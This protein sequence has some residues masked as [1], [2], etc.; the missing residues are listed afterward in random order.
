MSEKKTLVLP[1]RIVLGRGAMS[2]LGEYAAM[3]GD[4]ALLVASAEDSDRV[5]GILD[6][7]ASRRGVEFLYADF[8]GECCESAVRG[9]EGFCADSGAGVVIGL[10]GGK[11]IDTAKIIAD[12]LDLPMFSV[13]TTAATDA[14][15]SSLAIMYDDARHFVGPVSLR[16]N[17]A[18][19]LIDT[20]IIAK[21]PERFLVSGMGDAFSTFFEA[22]A[23]R[24]ANV[25]NNGGLSTLCAC[26]LAKLGLDTL[27]EK[28]AEALIACRSGIVTPALED[29]IEVNIVMSGIGFESAGVAAAH[30]L[31]GALELL[32]A[33]EALHG[34]T[35]AFG[36]LAQLVLE[37][38]PGG[39][40]RSAINFYRQVG[41]P[42]RLRDIGIESV[43]RETLD[44]ASELACAPGSVIHNMPFKVTPDMVAASVTAADR[45]QEMF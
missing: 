12:R 43:A 2:E 32:G 8:P 38:A 23:C 24:R 42:L 27:L 19:V 36:T 33:T 41:L 15:C 9:L 14:P 10:G 13:P 28:G 26:G 17:P 30:G 37:N 3:C 6:E 22:R 39:E 18:L 25:L 7:T 11:G 34:E 4:R 5:R 29:I 20:E 16:R 1:G 31:A 40:I 45:L 35:V 21:A 44:A